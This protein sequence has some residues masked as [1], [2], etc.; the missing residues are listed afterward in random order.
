MSDSRPVRAWTLLPADRGDGRDDA[1]AWA[2]TAAAGFGAA[3][4]QV[5]DASVDLSDERL[6]RLASLAHR[7]GLLVGAAPGTGVRPDTRHAWALEE[8]GSPGSVV[9]ATRDLDAT[10][11][12]PSELD[13]SRDTDLRA[14][15]PAAAPP[16]KETHL[17]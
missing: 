8:A 14:A 12:A 7:H 4:V 15:D 9:T 17:P 5:L 3:Q 2:T 11:T 13:D 1:V 16:P 10:V 6:D